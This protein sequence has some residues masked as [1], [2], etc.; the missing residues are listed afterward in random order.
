MIRG[1]MMHRRAMLVVILLMAG[2]VVG[3]PVSAV[4]LVP[5]APGP[6]AMP[7]DALPALPDRFVKRLAKARAQFLEQA[8]AIIL[9]YGT[10]QG[11]DPAGIENFIASGRAAIRA[12]EIARL[13]AGD[14][15]NDGALDTG[16]LA[17]LVA[18]AAAS[19][20]GQLQLA[21]GSADA[22]RDGTAT[23]NELRAFGQS[24]ALDQIDEDEAA[25]WRRFMLFDLD[26][27]GRVMLAEVME[28]ADGVRQGG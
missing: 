25:D 23:A 24:K 7:L 15:N 21:H 28:V 27:N 5:A 19:K 20:R 14:L 17:V 10:A 12:R 3:G 18:N 13:L 6:V 2:S 4:G 26:H 11:V 1:V 8:A 16:E 9:G 22:D